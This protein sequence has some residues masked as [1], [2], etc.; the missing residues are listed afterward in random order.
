MQEFSIGDFQLM[1][2]GNPRPGFLLQTPIKG[3]E[4]PKHRTTSYSRPGRDGVTVSAKF[5]DGR[6]IELV[7]MI[8]AEAGESFADYEARR[9]AFI[10]AVM[11]QRDD[12]GNPRPIRVSF[13]TL[14]GQSLYC[15]AYFNEP[16]MPLESPVSTTFMVTAIGNLIYGSATTTSGNISR[17]VGGGL[18]IPFTIPAVASGSTGGSV[19]M[20]N[21]G[22][23]TTF[24]SIDANGDGGIILTGPLTNPIISN[25]TTGKF[26]E[27]NYTLA[28]G[29][30]IQIDMDNQLILLNGSSSLISKKTTMSDWWGL[31]PG[32]NLLSISTTNNA[33]TGYFTVT[34]NPAYIGV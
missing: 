19:V 34:Y 4:S 17:P 23:T 11:N 26:I 33:D 13:T 20:T 30:Y 22:T 8:Y 28:S 2:G 14:A 1:T 9:S 10:G 12:N 25:L 31:E 27:F 3:L 7:G 29:D 16:V 21:S 6:L 32:P 24:P 18:I 15:D 5:L